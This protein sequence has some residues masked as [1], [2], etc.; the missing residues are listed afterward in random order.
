MKLS[1]ES[2]RPRLYKKGMAAKEAGMMIMD[3]KEVRLRR[4]QIK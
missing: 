2:H 3:R 4:E 1:R